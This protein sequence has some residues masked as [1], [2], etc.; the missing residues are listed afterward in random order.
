M[1]DFTQAIKWMK[2]GGSVK[3]SNWDNNI[4]IWKDFKFFRRIK[5]SIESFP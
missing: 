5:V 1:A 2:E 4:F 3:R